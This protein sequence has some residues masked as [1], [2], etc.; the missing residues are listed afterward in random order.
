MT[1][2]IEA[3]PGRRIPHAH[4]TTALE[5][6]LGRIPLPAVGARVTFTDV[7]GPKKGV[8]MECALLVTLPGRPP[9]RIAR[10]AATP[11]LAFDLGYDV[12]VRR[13]EQMRARHDDARRRPKKYYGAKRLLA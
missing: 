1:I 8:D 4:V 13:L 11:R 6:A 2:R 9:L 10:R 7:N 5:K 12:L 3:M